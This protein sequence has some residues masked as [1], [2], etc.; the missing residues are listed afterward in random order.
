MA[1]RC[2]ATMEGERMKLI[3][4]K[5]NFIPIDLYTIL[6]SIHGI[7]YRQLKSQNDVLPG[8]KEVETE[9]YGIP[10]ES[11]TIPRDVHIGLC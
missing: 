4:Y 3:Q 2:G 10:V 8:I 1:L 7:Q 6:I 5:R 11:R 9:I